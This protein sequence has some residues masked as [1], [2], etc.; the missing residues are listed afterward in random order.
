MARQAAVGAG[1]F[2]AVGGDGL[3]E[4]GVSIVF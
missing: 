1:E 3:E 2:A 4:E